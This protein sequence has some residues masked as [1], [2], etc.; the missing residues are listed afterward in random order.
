MNLTEGLEM[1]PPPA[2]GLRKRDRRGADEELA[3]RY[4]AR[5]LAALPEQAVRILLFG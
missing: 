1:A 5:L 2:L 4:R 3:A